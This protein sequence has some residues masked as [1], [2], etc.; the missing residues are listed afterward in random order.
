MEYLWRICWIG[1]ESWRSKIK[2]NIIEIGDIAFLMFERLIQFYIVCKFVPMYAKLGAV[3][4]LAVEGDVLNFDTADGMRFI[5]TDEH[6][7]GNG[8][9]GAVGQDLNVFEFY[10]VNAAVLTVL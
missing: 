5:K 10:V 4:V 7:F 8:K 9:V 6:R 1:W 3:E 2:G